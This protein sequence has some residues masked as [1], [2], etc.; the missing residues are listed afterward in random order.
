MCWI[1]GHKPREGFSSKETV[2]TVRGI[3][4]YCASESTF[5]TVRRYLERNH[6]CRRCGVHF[7]EVLDV[8]DSHITRVEIADKNTPTLDLSKKGKL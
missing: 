2:V 5:F 3:G 4:A 8:D 6:T 7:S 1:F